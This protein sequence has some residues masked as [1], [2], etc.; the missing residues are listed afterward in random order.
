MKTSYNEIT[1]FITRDG[2][3]IRELMHPDSHGNQNQ[4]LSE[5]IIEPGKETLLHRHILSEEL[6][7]VIAGTGL[8]T[9]AKQQFE[10]RSGDTI[11]IHP[12]VE[13]KIRNTGDGPLRILCCC[14][15]PY[16][17]SDTELLE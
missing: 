7:H 4:S 3:L 9:L 14:T 12:G 13:H 1:A 10:V 17:H 6:Y 8:M 15:P 11:G 5:A 2:S 16:Q